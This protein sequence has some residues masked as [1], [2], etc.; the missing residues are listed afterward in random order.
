MDTKTK[1]L[2]RTSSLELG[3]QWSSGEDSPHLLKDISGSQR[4]HGQ[5]GTTGQSVDSSK[6]LDHAALT[7]PVHL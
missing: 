1:L 4:Y 3:E 5:S 6:S 2:W 7:S